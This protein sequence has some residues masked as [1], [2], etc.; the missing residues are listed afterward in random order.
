M[1][2]MYLMMMLDFHTWIR[3]S[4]WIVMGLCIY[5]S[6]GMWKSKERLR[7]MQ[8][9]FVNNK[10]TEVCTFTSSKEIL[11]PTGQ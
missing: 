4:I 10:Q 7:R 3:F 5:V 8:N 1:I 6:Y 11:V 2:N 9:V